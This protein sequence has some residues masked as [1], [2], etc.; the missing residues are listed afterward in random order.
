MT[1]ETRIAEMWHVTVV[2]LLKNF[3]GR[4]KK[5]SNNRVISILFLTIVAYVRRRTKVVFIYIY[6]TT[7]FLKSFTTSSL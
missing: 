4:K 2:I 1:I 3:T 7:L 6:N 5:I